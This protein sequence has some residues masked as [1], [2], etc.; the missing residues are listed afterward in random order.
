MEQ[1]EVREYLDYRGE[2]VEE[3][4][5]VEIRDL[6]SHIMKQLNPEERHILCLKFYRGFSFRKIGIVLG[7]CRNTAL[8]KYKA[9][10]K[11]VKDEQGQGK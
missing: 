4:R 7:V 3:D 1:R 9:I 8:N 2:Y 6:V 11:A 5:S 10:M